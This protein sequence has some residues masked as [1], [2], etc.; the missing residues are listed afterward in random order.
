MREF[1]I[2]LITKYVP[3]PAEREII[4]SMINAGEEGLAI[5]I[6]AENYYENDICLTSEEN[7]ELKAI[8]ETLQLPR[9]YLEMIVGLRVTPN[10]H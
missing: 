2:G 4:E 8:A 3:L 9:V 1:L 7:S 6:I 5:E 10:A